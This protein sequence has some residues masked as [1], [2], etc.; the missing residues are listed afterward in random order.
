MDFVRAAGNFYFFHFPQIVMENTTKTSRTK[1]SN[2][3]VKVFRAP[4]GL[5]ASVFDNH[6]ERDGKATS[7]YKVSLQRTYKEG[8]KFLTTSTLSRDEL[9]PAAHL[10][11]QA[12]AW[13][14]VAEREE[15][16]E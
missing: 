4:H 1:T 8:D 14:I 6:V 7:F 16:E 11:T 3:P 9:L 2:K 13:I 10:L 5:S 12:Y 15:A